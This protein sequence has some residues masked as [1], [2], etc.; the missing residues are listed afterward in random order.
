[1]SIQ[2]GCANERL[3]QKELPTFVVGVEHEY[4][5]ELSPL[6][7][8]PMPRTTDD[9]LAEAGCPAGYQASPAVTILQSSIYFDDG[10]WSLARSNTSLAVIIN[11]GP[12]RAISWL[13]LKRTLSWVEGRRDTLEVAYR[14]APQSVPN[15][16]NT[17][18]CLPLCLLQEWLG[19]R[20]KLAPYAVARQ[21]RSQ[22]LLTSE[23]GSQL[24]ISL[25]HIDLFGPEPSDASIG[26]NRWLEI[27]TNQTDTGSLRT[28]TDWSNRLC[29]YLELIPGDTT[30]P[31]V[32]ARLMGWQ[33]TAA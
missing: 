26:R 29:D 11:H 23:R 22:V 27:E 21:L 24:G 16:L 4:K 32:A 14:T 7:A 2:T 25:D 12:A 18:D 17:W 9:V 20:P 8:E 28:L 3:F 1:V 33:D 19:K 15:V 10:K 13:M 5:W 30:K 31:V 6:L